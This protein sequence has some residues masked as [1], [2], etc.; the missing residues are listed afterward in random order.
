[1]STVSSGAGNVFQPGDVAYLPGYNNV[2]RFALYLDAGSLK[3]EQYGSELDVSDMV[4]DSGAS[5]NN[6]NGP[7]IFRVG[8]STS[9]NNGRNYAPAAIWPMQR[10]AYVGR[11]VQPNTNI[12]GSY[13]GAYDGDGWAVISQ[14]GYSDDDTGRHGPQGE[15]IRVSFATEFAGDLSSDMPAATAGPGSGAGFTQPLGAAI[16]ERPFPNP[17]KNSTTL[18][19]TL[20]PT[21]TTASVGNAQQFGY[22]FYGQNA[23]PPLAQTPTGDGL[24]YVTDGVN[25]EFLAFGNLSWSQNKLYDLGR[26]LYGSTAATW[27]ATAST[28]TFGGQW[29]G[30]PVLYFSDSLAGL[31]PTGTI[32]VGGDERHLHRRRHRQ[33]RADR[34]RHRDAREDRERDGRDAGRRHDPL[35][36][37][38]AG[39]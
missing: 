28:T 13:V 32:L 23:E 14:D 21:D 6:N 39:H 36:R 1:V 25:E 26:G 12:D 7:I 30:N 33:R 27:A 31:T 38:A 34:L 35:L 17:N 4:W 11:T 22:L 8:N 3:V 5:S 16:G 37:R 29:L 10:W 15:Q 24:L 18:T 20:N 9:Q 19:A 2:N